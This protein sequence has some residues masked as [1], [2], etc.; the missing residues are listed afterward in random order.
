[1]IATSTVRRVVAVAI[2]ALT[3]LLTL[4]ALQQV[5]RLGEDPRAA[6]CRRRG[7]GVAMLHGEFYGCLHIETN[8]LD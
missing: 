6:D 7:M 2:V 4:L 1:M 8:T 5:F 3:L